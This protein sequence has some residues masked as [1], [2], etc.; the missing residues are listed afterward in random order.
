VD[1][2]KETGQNTPVAAVQLF[3]WT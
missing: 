3:T 2:C 1:Y